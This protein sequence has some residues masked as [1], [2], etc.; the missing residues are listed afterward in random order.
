VLAA[1]LAAAGL[2]ADDWPQWGGPHRNFRASGAQ[3]AASWPSS[4]PRE[5]WSRPL[6][7]GYAAIA[8]EGNRLYTMY[9]RG[10]TEV[11]VALDAATGKTVW[12]HRYDA[13][14]LEGMRLEHGPGPHTTPLI[15]GNRLFAA[16]AMG[17]LHAL[18]KNTGRVLW[19]RNLHEM[20][21]FVWR[22]G[23]SSSP[24]AHKD[25]VIVTTGKAG[26][27]V[28]AFRQSDGEVVWKKQDFDY[29]PSSP[30]LIDV[31]GQTQLVVFMGEGPAGLDPATGELLWR[32]PHATRGGLNISTPVWGEDNLLFLSSA[33]DGG[34]RML[35]LA[36][37]GQKTQVK[38]LWSTSR[39]RIHF[40]TAIR[41]GDY[42]Y[43]SS[44][45]FGPAFL[46]AV[47]V[48]TGE[49]AWQDRSFA[50]ASMVFADG[51][52]IVLDEDGNLGL[53]T[54]SPSGPKV[55]ARAE[56]LARNAWT[57][58]TLVGTRL[59]LRDRRTIRALDLQ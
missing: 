20:T 11:V 27:S 47:N 57:P 54:L 9:R 43:G 28:I 21:G 39:M 30:I 4:G 36:R 37:Q 17:H 52:A 46:A 40:G 24:I 22:R 12:E 1:S 13:P 59:Y 42:V 55:L 45:D 5:V 7:E 14:A 49:V 34:S 3:V 53:V 51:K 35:H 26:Q 2:L 25:T 6:G 44:G 50:R 38:E 29:G 58:P 10:E 23:Y 48:K 41:L 15:V 18:D 31:D 56:V 33:Y 16:G 19:S 32:H 8:A